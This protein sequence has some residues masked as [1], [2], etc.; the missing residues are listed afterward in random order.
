[1][2]DADATCVHERTAAAPVVKHEHEIAL[3]RLLKT[4]LPP[5]LRAGRGTGTFVDPD[6]EDALTK[7]ACTFDSVL[8]FRA[9]RAERLASEGIAATTRDHHL[10]RL[11]WT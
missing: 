11:H 5:V 1:M 9:V 8:Q 6:L 4:P 3:S 7:N 2:T 10:D